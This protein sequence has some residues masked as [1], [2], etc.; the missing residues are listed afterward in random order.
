MKKITFDKLTIYGY[1]SGFP[2]YLLE[3]SQHPGRQFVIARC[4]KPL[5]KR[6]PVLFKLLN[7][8]GLYERA[9][10]VPLGKLLS[11]YSK[12]R[13]RAEDRSRSALFT[14]GEEQLVQYI[15]SCLA[16][17]ATLTLKGEI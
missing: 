15:E 16:N 12:T 9:S 8:W 10:G 4:S 13:A 11:V 3:H 1:R 17:V 7:E 5:D 6:N 14:V 2:G